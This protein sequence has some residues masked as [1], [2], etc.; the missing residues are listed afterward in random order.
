MKGRIIN[1]LEDPDWNNLLLTGQNST[2]F[3]TANWARVL[4]ET[5]RYTPVYFTIITGSTLSALL[6]VMAVKSL[7]TGTRGVS[8]PFTDHCPT[9]AESEEQY[10][11]LVD[12]AIEYGKNA[13][14][15]T[16][17][18]RNSRKPGRDAAPSANF[19]THTLDLSLGEANLLKSF[20][21]STRRNINK[22]KREGVTVEHL[23]TLDA[24]KAFYRLNCITRKHHG[25]P[26][27]PFQFFKN[28]FRCVIAENHGFV[29]L[30]EFSKRIIA[31]AIFF[32][33]GK[34][35]MYKYGASDRSFQYL[36]ANNLI[37]WEAVRWY[38]ENGFEALDFGRTEAENDGLLQFK[39]GWGTTEQT[40][41]YYKFDMKKQAY[42]PQS[43]GM[44]TSYPLLRKAPVPILRL[45]GRLLYRHMG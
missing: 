12:R 31:G 44:K 20:R 43:S 37:M 28:I 32:H 18:L 34:E 10:H 5:Y 6:P 13:G 2:F 26:P 9:I 7:L 30:A 45:A 19:Y 1:P 22:A 42:V 14:W 38:A 24:V 3:H 21:N 23:Q 29:V 36:R 35:A 33:W 8:L 40:L 16:L 39:R 25:L 4:C 27:Q 17:E 15:K 11:T 41:D